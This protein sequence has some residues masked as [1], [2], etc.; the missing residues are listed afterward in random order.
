[1]LCSHFEWSWL[2]IRYHDIVIV[3]IDVDCD[4]YIFIQ[5]VCLYNG[6]DCLATVL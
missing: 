3:A 1:M 2:D 6:N 5:L 4:D